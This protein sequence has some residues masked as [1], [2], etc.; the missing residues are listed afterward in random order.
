MAFRGGSNGVAFSVRWCLSTKKLLTTF[1]TAK[2]L[3]PIVT[4]AGH[5]LVLF[6]YVHIHFAPSQIRMKGKNPLQT[7]LCSEGGEWAIT[8]SLSRRCESNMVS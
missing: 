7:Q 3:H 6:M 5:T 8:L 2:I 4:N 1:Q